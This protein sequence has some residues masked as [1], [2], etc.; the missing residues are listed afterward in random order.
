MQCTQLKTG[1]SALI[2]RINLNLVSRRR[3]FH[4]GISEGEIITMIK[5]A[6]LKDPTIYLVNGNYLALRN[7][8][9]SHI[10]VKLI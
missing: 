8:D 7:E 4:L 1:Q 9:A 2:E 5:I 3:C 10:E 6:P